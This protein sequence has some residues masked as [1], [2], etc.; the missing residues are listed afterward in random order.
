MQQQN[1]VRNR[2][3]IKHISKI[4]LN[5]TEDSNELTAINIPLK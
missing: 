2:I 1:K 4:D 5:I 3:F